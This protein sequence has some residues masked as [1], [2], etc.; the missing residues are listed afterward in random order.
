[1]ALQ[2]PSLTVNAGLRR[3]LMNPF[4]LKSTFFSGSFNFNLH[5]HPIT[6]APPRISMRVASKQ[7]YI[8]RDCGYIYNDRTPFDK[9][10]DNYFCPVC[11]APKRRFRSY[12]PA[13]TRDANDT[14]V[15]KARKAELQR[16][17]AIGKAL[18]IAIVVGIAVLAGLYFYLNNQY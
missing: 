2:A 5:L 10:P 18:P 9:L 17:E 7:A 11:G 4:A 14:S 12:A 8:C 16:D 3:P 6:S 15:R 13:V 1:M